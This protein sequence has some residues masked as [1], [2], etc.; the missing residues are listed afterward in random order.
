M[1]RELAQTF[2]VAPS[3]LYTVIMA[4]LLVSAFV[5]GFAL[6][7][8]LNHW[9]KKRQGTWGE[10]FFALLESLPLP[11]LV[12][13][14]LYGGI[15]MLPLPR[16]FERIG[17]KLIFVLLIL[18]L[19]YFPAKVVILLL[20]RLVQ[21]EPHL[22]H[23]A[24]PAVFLIR[25]L[26]AVLAVIIVLENLGIS[27]TAVWTTLGVGSVAV[28]LALQE[29]LSNLFAGLYILADRPVRGGDYIKLDGGQEGFVVR[30]GW[31]STVIRALSNNNVIV[32]NA[33]LAKAI[34]TN[35][36]QPVPQMSYVLPVSVAYGSD[37]AKVERALLDAV[38]GALRDGVEGLLPIPAPSVRAIPGSSQSSLDF[39][40][41]VQVR[42]FTDQYFVQ[43][44]LRKRILRRFDAE[45]IKIPFPTRMIDLEPGTRDLLAKREVKP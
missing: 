13:A 34:I 30:V 37:P 35:F 20:R 8:V 9:T 38:S 22:A 11:L 15:D 16:T 27:L 36:S 44:E 19:F 39:S 7:R 21:R 45:G 17:S 31:R 5:V 26:F 43:S 6:H 1:V 41:S 25:A 18:I 28:A 33:T 14:A 42:Q 10:Y 24:Q 4:A 12:V 2:H 32:P 29:T 3:V 40:L 23:V